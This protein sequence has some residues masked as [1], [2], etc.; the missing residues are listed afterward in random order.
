M[1]IST[2]KKA[3]N[4]YNSSKK[5]FVSPRKITYDGIIF[6]YK[7]LVDQITIDDSLIE[8]AYKEGDYNK[9]Q[10][11]SYYIT[12]NQANPSNEDKELFRNTVNEI[13][14]KYLKSNLNEEEF[15]KI[16]QNYQEKHQI[17]LIK[18]GWENE[19]KIPE[20][21]LTAIVKT[22]KN[23]LS[24]IEYNSQYNIHYAVV[25]IDKRAF[26]PK[27]EAK[28]SIKES[29]KKDQA[30]QLAQKF[31]YNF[32]EKVKNSKD[33]LTTLNN[34]ITEDKKKFTV[35]KVGDYPPTNLG[36]FGIQSILGAFANSQKIYNINLNKENPLSDIITMKDNSLLILAFRKEILAKQKPF[37]QVKDSIIQ[38]ILFQDTLN[39]MTELVNSMVSKYKNMMKEKTLDSKFLEK[40]NFKKL[41][42]SKREIIPQLKDINEELIKVLDNNTE[43]YRI[44]VFLG[45]TEPEKD[46]F[47]R[48]FQEYKQY[49]KNLEAYNIIIKPLLEKFKENVIIY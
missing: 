47:N 25:P 13:Y 30:Y 26:I 48:F 16:S 46:V 40:E 11:K 18:S 23:K 9:K 22:P 34:L 4:K 38:D 39:S 2:L 49:R 27:Q 31:A 14:N 10:H 42:L 12:K 19:E 45:F 5:D 6:N 33:K 28:Q 29:L 32:I 7:T 35:Q 21:L 8:Q 36:L 15:K 41:K 24:S 17:R 20:I 3:Q 43:G 44:Y 1:S 37:S